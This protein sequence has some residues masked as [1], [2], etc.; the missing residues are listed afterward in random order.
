MKWN[1][2]GPKRADID[3]LLGWILGHPGEDLSVAAL[4]DRMATSPRNFAGSF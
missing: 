4:A 1:E 3:Q 2:A